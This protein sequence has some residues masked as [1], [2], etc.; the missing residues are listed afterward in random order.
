M[1]LKMYT[2]LAGMGLVISPLELAQKL[3][4]MPILDTIEFMRDLIALYGTKVADEV[5]DLVS[6]ALNIEGNNIK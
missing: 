1:K 5:I 3:I 4:K 6:K 2:N